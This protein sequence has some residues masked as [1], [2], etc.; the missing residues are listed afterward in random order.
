M[1]NCKKSFVGNKFNVLNAEIGKSITEIDDISDK[2]TKLNA[3]KTVITG[4]V[5]DLSAVSEQNAASN[6]EVNASITG[7]TDAI[8]NIADSSVNTDKSVDKLLDTISYF[9]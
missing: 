8:A 3:A 2:V 7:I 4:S 9:K 5:E 1:Q 6:E